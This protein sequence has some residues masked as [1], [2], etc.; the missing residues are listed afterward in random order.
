MIEIPLTRNKV[1]LIDDCDSHFASL[2]WMASREVCGYAVH[3]LPWWNEKRTVIFLHKEIFGPV[4]DGFLVDHINGNSY[5]CRRENLRSVSHAV[6]TR[7]RSGPNKNNKSSRYLGVSWIARDRV[8]LA[9]IRAGGK[10]LHLGR[11]EKETDAAAA[12]AKAER[13]LWGVEPRRAKDL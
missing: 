10:I 3:Y 9:Q 2:P 7:N 5:D 8:F 11:F 13:D 4:E 12:R 1:A 6:N